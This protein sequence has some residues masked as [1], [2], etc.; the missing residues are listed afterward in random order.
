MLAVLQDN[1]LLTS[2]KTFRN[3]HRKKKNNPKN[4]R[5]NKQEAR[6]WS[7]TAAKV[8]EGSLEGSHLEF[9]EVS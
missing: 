7:C 5:K 1:I 4:Q 2:R 6:P 3:F 9:R 8:T